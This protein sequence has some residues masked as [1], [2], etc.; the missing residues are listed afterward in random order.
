VPICR[1]GRGGDFVAVEFARNELLPVTFDLQRLLAPGDLVP[2]G[3]L[4]PADGLIAARP[5]IPAGPAVSAALLV[6][7][8]ELV[9][10]LLTEPG[11]AVQKVADLPSSR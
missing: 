10:A 4:V 8:L 1:S 11:D 9:P 6:P 3:P 5:L 2:T 7:P